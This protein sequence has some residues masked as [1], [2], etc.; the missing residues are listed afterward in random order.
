[1]PKPENLVW[2]SVHLFQ[3]FFGPIPVSLMAFKIDIY[4]VTVACRQLDDS[5]HI[6]FINVVALQYLAL[7]VIIKFFLLMQ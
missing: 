1:M 3:L 2:A 5:K 4:K 7:L 6:F